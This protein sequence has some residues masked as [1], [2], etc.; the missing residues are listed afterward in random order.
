MKNDN[1][2][3]IDSGDDDDDDKKNHFDED[4]EKDYSAYDVSTDDD[5]EYKPLL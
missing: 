1:V 5:N 3:F 2:I 4:N